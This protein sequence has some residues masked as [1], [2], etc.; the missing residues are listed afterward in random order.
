MPPLILREYEKTQGVYL[1]LT[2][3]EQLQAL[4]NTITVVPTAGSTDRWDL[5]PASTIGALHLDGL[6]VLIVPKLSVDRVMFLM[7]Y[8]LRRV[9][10]LES[11]VGLDA[12]VDVVEAA[13]ATFVHHA[14][15]ALN[16]GVQQGYRSV[17]ESS[18]TVRGQLRMGDQIRRRYGPYPPAEI[19]YDDFTVDIEINRLLLAA[20]HRLLRLRL[21]YERSRAGLRGIVRRLEGVTLVE[22]DARRLP[23]IVFSRL[24]ER[25][26][27][28]VELARLILQSMSFDVRA[29]GV[30]ATAFLVNMNQVFEDFLVQAL[31]DALGP[32]GRQLVQGAHGHPLFLDEARRVRLE[33]DL[34]FWRGPEC[35][36]VGDAKYKRITSTEFPNADL[37]QAMAY[38]VATGRERA[39][40]VYAAGEE[41]PASHRV[42]HIGKRVDVVT[43]DLSQPPV[44]VLDQVQ[45]LAGLIRSEVAIAA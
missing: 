39:L 33:P 12:D 3:R 6:D 14:S 40:L 8:A 26:G 1:T 20:A 35:L 43:L 9:H 18:L 22:Y 44:G 16:R 41:Q 32:S 7:S 27:P 29:G 10:Q 30:T 19:T 28:A 4:T 38:A 23:L 17:D 45:D 24:N 25:Y 37:Y 34:S 2:Q 21:R 5:T 42:V 15:R 11:P 36:F 31:R 13:V